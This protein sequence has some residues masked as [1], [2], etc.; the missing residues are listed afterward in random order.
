MIAFVLLGAAILVFLFGFILGV[1]WKVY[2][3]QSE[4]KR[5]SDYRFAGYLTAEERRRMQR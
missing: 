2:V 4:Q 3:D 1:A 5:R